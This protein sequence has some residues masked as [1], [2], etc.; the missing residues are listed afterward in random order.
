VRYNHI[1]T[2]GIAQRAGIL[3]R[4]I[5]AAQGE[6]AQTAQETSIG[7]AKAQRPDDAPPRKGRNEPHIHDVLRWRPIRQGG[8]TLGVGINLSELNNSVKHWIIQE[9][10]SDER[11]VVRVAGRTNPVG[12]PSAGATYIRTVKPQVGRRIRSSLVWATGPGGNYVRPGAGENQQLYLRK[13]IKFPKGVQ[14]A[15]YSDAFPGRSQ[16][17]IIIGKEIKPRHFVQKGGEA[18]FRVYRSSVLAAARSQFRKKR[19]A[20]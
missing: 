6:A 5:K 11:A 19:A 18:G 15:A 7:L 12:R 17:G 8:S 13:M 10:G 9:I 3:I 14:G 16:P 2:R 20:L 4:E 1:L